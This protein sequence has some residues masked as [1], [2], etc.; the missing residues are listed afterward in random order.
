MLCICYLI[1]HYHSI[2]GIYNTKTSKL[3]TRLSRSFTI[4]KIPLLR[5][6]FNNINN[7][8]DYNF[9]LRDMKDVLKR[10]YGQLFYDINT[11]LI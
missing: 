3:K 7:N 11:L 10:V 2:V 6:V 4:S 8:R 5:V 9:E 1:L